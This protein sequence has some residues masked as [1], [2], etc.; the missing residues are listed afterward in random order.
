Q[1]VQHF[2]QY[3]HGMPMPS[4]SEARLR[5]F[6]LEHDFIKPGDPLPA[7]PDVKKYLP[8]PTQ[9]KELWKPMMPL[10]ELRDLI[11]K[12]GIKKVAKM[13]GTNEPWLSAICRAL[14]VPVPPAGRSKKR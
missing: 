10:D 7:P 3:P 14:R 13:H 1:A 9:K 6:L 5:A 11:F 12:H 8:K 4:E 2:G